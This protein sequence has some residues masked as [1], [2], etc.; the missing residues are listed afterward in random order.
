MADT[1]CITIVEQTI[2]IHIEA[3][4]LNVEL[5]TFSALALRFRTQL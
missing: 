4:A 3:F 2:Q 1:Q 5:V